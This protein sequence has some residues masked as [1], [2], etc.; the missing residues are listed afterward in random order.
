MMHAGA[1]FEERFYIVGGFSESN[2]LAADSW[3]RDDRLPRVKNI[4]ILM[5]CIVNESIV[6]GF[7]QE[8]T[9]NSF[10]CSIFRFYQR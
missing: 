6:S 2:V 5:T 7:I 10:K 8:E 9:S 4:M 1:Y 3:Y